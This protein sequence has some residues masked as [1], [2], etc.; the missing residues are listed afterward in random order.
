MGLGLVQ[1][2]ARSVD[3]PLLCKYKQYTMET[4]FSGIQ[5]SGELHLGNY[6]GAVRNWVALQEDYH[7][8]FCIV[9]YHAITQD[10][11]PATL[12]RRTLEMATDL[13]A[14]GIDPERSVLFVQSSVP[15]HTELCWIL[16]TVTPFGDLGR[17]TQFKDKAEKQAD[18]INAGLFSY[19]VLQTADIIMYRARLVPVGVDQVQHIE[20][21]REVVRKPRCRSRSAIPSR[22]VRTT[23]A[24]ARNLQRRRLIPRASDAKIRETRMSAIFTL[25]TRSS[26]TPSAF[27]GF[28]QGV[29]QQRLAASIAKGRW[30]IA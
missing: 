14:C 28:A 11:T 20:L 13:I 24:F 1:R 30:P 4:V 29:R 17:M 26:R 6:L 10:Y 8:F 27:S 23:R 16:N 25:S 15:E 18:N 9:D 12:S 21:A 19:P 3:G 5:P 22:W 7:C 2:K